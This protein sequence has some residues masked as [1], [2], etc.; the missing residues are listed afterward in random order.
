MRES[1]GQRR[2]NWGVEQGEASS[3]DEASRARYRQRAQRFGGVETGATDDGLAIVFLIALVALALVA[4]RLFWFHVIK[5]PE[6]SE[7]ARNNR[8]DETVIHA[9]RGTIYDR[10]GNVLAISVDAKTIYCNPMP[11]E[12]PS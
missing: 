1:K 8:T 7:A 9:R 6:Y 5:A 3:Y 2:S 11:S 10:N 4:G 12:R